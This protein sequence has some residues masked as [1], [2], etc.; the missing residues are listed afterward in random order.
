MHKQSITRPTFEE[1]PL[2]MEA[3]LHIIIM[4]MVTY[5]WALLQYSS[6]RA[7]HKYHVQKLC[8]HNNTDNV[9]IVSEGEITK[10]HTLKL[11][12]YKQSTI[13]IYCT[14]LLRGLVHRFHRH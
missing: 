8:I 1:V 9:A 6:Q 4:G 5:K 10:K 3:R 7:P 13:I 12:Q 11:E 2:E 14:L